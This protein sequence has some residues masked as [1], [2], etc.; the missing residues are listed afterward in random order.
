METASHIRPPAVAG[1]FYPGEAAALADAVD[2]LLGTRENEEP[3]PSV[4]MLLSPHAGY[5]YSGAIAG[6]G[7][8]RARVATTHPS[9]AFIIGPSHV[10]TFRHTSVYPGG[11]YRTPLGDVLVD[12][13]AAQQL[14]ADDA[15]IRLSGAGHDVARGGRGEHG[16]EVQLPFLQRCFPGMRIV[17][18]V[19]GSQSWEACDAL[20]R[21]ISALADWRSDVVIASSDL[22]HFYSDR[23]AREL[24]G[25][26]CETL[27]TMDARELFDRISRGECE[28]CGA[29]PVV[30]SLIATASLRH[31]TGELLATA[32]S[33][34]VNHDRS[35]VVGYAAA[36]VTGDPA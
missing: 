21:A 16:I 13:R 34:D 18:V 22:S 11:A 24:D 30:A 33:G 1:S 4:R 19:M 36:V 25:V 32:N 6:R 29:G 14:A 8:E 17:P 20:G 2:R 12:T 9:R 5:M 31:R 15:S 3:L 27:L 10:E 26:F 35:S 7:F 23:R 28:A